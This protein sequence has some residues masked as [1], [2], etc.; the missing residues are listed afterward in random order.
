[1][2]E[3]CCKYYCN[4]NVKIEVRKD[5]NDN[6]TTTVVLD[7]HPNKVSIQLPAILARELLQQ[8]TTVLANVT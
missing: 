5:G 4:N 3:T 7:S 1:M 8:L 6:N 2:M